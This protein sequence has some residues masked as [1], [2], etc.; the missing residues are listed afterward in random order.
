MNQ[1]LRGYLRREAEEP[2]Q[3][4]LQTA[5]YVLVVGMVTILGV[6]LVMG[7]SDGLQRELEQVVAAFGSP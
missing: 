7:S 3:R 4:G 6:L 5:E 2:R 1:R